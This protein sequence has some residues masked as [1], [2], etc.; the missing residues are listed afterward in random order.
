MQQWI[1]DELDSCHLGDARLN[2]RYAKILNRFDV[3]PSLSIPASCRGRAEVEAAYRFFDNPKVT[4]AKLL[5]PHRAATI[6]RVRGTPVVLVAQDSSEVDLTR[7]RERVGGPLDEGHRWGLFA[8]PQ[9]VFTPDAVPLGVIECHLWARDPAELDK[10]AATKRR[11]RKAKPFEDKESVRWLNGYHAACALAEET[12]GTQ[13]VSLADSEG[14]IYE[15]LAERG[16]AD[17]I[18]RSGQDRAVLE[19][20]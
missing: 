2:S 18:V 17:W 10:D 1:T 20:G 6:E 16:A 8:H 14:D 13:V 19:G 4:P 12:P 11:Q 15:C 9:L 5:A 3:Q 7:R